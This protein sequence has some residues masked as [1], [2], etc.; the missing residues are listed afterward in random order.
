MADLS[1][2]PSINGEHV[3]MIRLSQRPRNRWNPAKA[4]RSV[5]NSSWCCWF[6]RCFSSSR[7]C[8]S[9]FWV[10]WMRRIFRLS[11]FLVLTVRY[12]NHF[13]KLFFT[14]T[15]HTFAIGP[16]HKQRSPSRKPSAIAQGPQMRRSSD[17]SLPK[18]RC[19]S[20]PTVL[21]AEHAFHASLARKRHSWAFHHHRRTTNAANIFHCN[22]STCECS[23][24]VTWPDG[25]QYGA[26][27]PTAPIPRYDSWMYSAVGCKDV[28]SC[29]H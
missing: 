9:F 11:T 4:R 24:R 7:N 20:P 6:H 27:E 21:A 19:P 23:S 10:E 18:F 13:S 16:I 5:T 22:G 29:S 25:P 17:H 12:H 15:K 2:T 26:K 28:T 1:E 14:A 3:V 8:V